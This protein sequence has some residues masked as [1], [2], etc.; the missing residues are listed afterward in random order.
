MINDLVN[1]KQQNSYAGVT[2]NIPVTLASFR[3][4]IEVKH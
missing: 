4:N 3:R 2:I 1:K